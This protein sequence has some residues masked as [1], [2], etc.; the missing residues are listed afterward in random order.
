[1]G[2]VG[3]GG[4]L[5]AI[6]ADMAWKG[7]DIRQNVLVAVGCLTLYGVEF[8]GVAPNFLRLT[9]TE[10]EGMRS[11]QVYSTADTI[12][13]HATV[14]PEVITYVKYVKGS[15]EGMLLAWLDAER[16]RKRR[17]FKA[18]ASSTE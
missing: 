18:L 8:V 13:F 11:Y 12:L 15:W 7:P 3:G 16:R 10:D 9:V 14:T 5:R 4:I 17:I 1:M 6:Q 2:S